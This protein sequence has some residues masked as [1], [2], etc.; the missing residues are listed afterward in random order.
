MA[1]VDLRIGGTTKLPSINPGNHLVL[2][3]TWDAS[4]DNGDDG[5][6]VKLFNIPANTYVIGVFASVTTAEGAASTVDVGDFGGDQDRWIDGL[7][8]NAVAVSGSKPG[9]LVDGTPNTFLPAFSHGRLYTSAAV[10][11]VE[12]NDDDTDTAVIEFACHCY[13]VI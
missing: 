4:V 6:F 12:V 1:I 9:I 10:I 2:K 5:D 13:E 8:I 7:D 3:R 11:S